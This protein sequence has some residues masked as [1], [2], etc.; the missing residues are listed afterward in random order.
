[1]SFSNNLTIVVQHNYKS[2]FFAH[3]LWISKIESKYLVFLISCGKSV[4]TTNANPDH[5]ALLRAGQSRFKLFGPVYL[6]E[7]L[8]FAFC[9]PVT[10][11]VVYSTRLCMFLGSLY[12]K[13]YG[14]N[15]RIQ[16]LTL[17]GHLT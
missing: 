6:S 10:F 9:R 2:T 12:C 14:P 17:D 8:G 5:T 16:K 15:R 11:F 1:M 4:R 7:N 3:I 13:Q